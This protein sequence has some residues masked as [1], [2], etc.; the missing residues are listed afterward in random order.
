RQAHGALS[1]AGRDGRRDA[2]FGGGAERALE[3]A[4]LRVPASP[5]RAGRERPRR[6]VSDRGA[7]AER[8]AMSDDVEQ[9]NSRGEL[10]HLINLGGLDRAHL[11]EIIDLA[12][13]YLT[14]V[15]ASAPR[16]DI[17]RGRTVANLFFE[18]STRTRASF[19]LA[20]KRLRA[21]VLNLDVNTSSRAKGESILDTIYT[22]QAMQ[23]DIFVVR[24]A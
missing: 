3:R 22:L 13:R 17:L 16:D 5:C 2:D 10:R 9:L 6:G 4:P 1:A 7:M 20:A 21:D 18:P 8:T 15:G 14:P 24:D 12:T 11:E 19:E 23:V